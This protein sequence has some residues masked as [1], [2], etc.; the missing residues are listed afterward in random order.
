MSTTRPDPLT[1][2]LGWFSLGLGLAQ[3][4]APRRFDR[5][6][7]VPPKGESAAWTLAGGLREL[8]HAAGILSRP[9]PTGWVWTRV[10]GDVMDL[11]LLAAAMRDKRANRARLAAA[12]GS[13]MGIAAV[14]A[15]DAIRLSS[16][17]GDR[18]Q[19]ETS[20]TVPV[21]A[22]R[23]LSSHVDASITIRRPR[24]EV[25]MAWGATEH[26]EGEGWETGI[27]FLPAPGD[28]GTEVHVH[29]DYNVP[30]GPVGVAMLKISGTEPRERV[31]DHLRRFKQIVETGEVVRSDGA[32]E[33]QLAPRHI[34]QRPAQPLERSI[35]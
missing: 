20:P 25:R 10:A 23:T 7:G 28:R 21:E 5:A 4:T 22:R 35:A 2:V 11:G 1:Q 29:V 24:D 26:P 19:G 31:M 12:A 14:D 34:K 3:L 18:T 27:E 33:G 13:V 32:P 16:T 9:K 15:F 17:D 30:G 6:I 8:A